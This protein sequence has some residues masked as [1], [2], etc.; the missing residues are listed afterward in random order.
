VT[1]SY[2]ASTS[3]VLSFEYFLQLVWSPTYECPLQLDPY[4]RAPASHPAPHILINYIPLFVIA[5]GHVRAG[6]GTAE[7]AGGGARRPARNAHPGET[8]LALIN[9]PHV[10]R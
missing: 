10:L 3:V 5:G 8:I 4:C 1:S 7:G 2:S 6:L 9:I